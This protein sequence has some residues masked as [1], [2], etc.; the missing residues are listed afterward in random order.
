M[1]IGVF[2]V[3]FGGL[4]FEE[5]LDKIAA[6]GVPCL[7]IGTANYPASQ[8]CDT[9]K[10]LKDEGLR[11]KFMAAIN[12]RNLELNTLSCHGNPLHPNRAFARAHDLGFRQTCDLASKLGVKKIVAFS[13]CPGDHPGAKYPNWVTCA[14][15]PDYLK[16]LDWQWEKVV[17]PY[18]KEAA[19][20]AKKRGVTK[21]AFEM[22]PG[23]VVYN[24]ETCL[25]LRN[26][27]GP[28]LGAN[29]DPSHL[30]WQGMDIPSVIRELKGAI[31]HFH[32]K[33]C[34]IDPLNTG[35]NGVLDTKSYGD[36]SKRSWIFRTVGYGH[37]ALVWKDIVSNLIMAGYNDV[38]SIEHED[39]LMSLDEG[40]LKGV[41]F[42]K[43][44][45]ISEKMGKMHWA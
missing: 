11:R 23:F 2:T 39:S 15:P 34:R 43:S 4:P 6:A 32:A 19:A 1:K 27:V 21:I 14:W 42:L 35:K 7:E 45:V 30:F 12:S 25:R 33:D 17:I 40:F 37:D 29:L 5:A 9:P 3:L 44:V 26:A 31:H 41:D 18:W 10:L 13:G 38:L 22:H 16:I 28:I 36:E 8:H 24:P 20:Y